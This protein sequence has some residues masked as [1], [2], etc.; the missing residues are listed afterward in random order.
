MGDLLPGERLL[1]TGSPARARTFRADLKLPGLLLAALVSTVAVWSGHGP[2]NTSFVRDLLVL[3]TVLE[4][5][6]LGLAAYWFLYRKPRTLRE[7]V[8][9]ISDRRVVVSDNQHVTAAFLDQLAEPVVAGGRDL[10]VRDLTPPRRSWL[11]P[12]SVG[13][14]FTPAEPPLFPALHDLPDAELVRRQLSDARQR[15]LRGLLDIEPAGF[16]PGDPPPSDFVPAPG[17]QILW[18]GHPVDLPWWFG[19][20]DVFYSVYHGA[21]LAAIP[22][23]FAWAVSQPHGLLP[24]VLF[25]S[26]VVLVFGYPAFG[27]LLHRRARIK[28]STYVLTSSRLIAI[29]PGS[30]IQSPL[31]Q[32]LPPEERGSSL[33]MAAAWPGPLATTP[34]Q[35]LWPAAKSNPPQLIGLPDPQAVA[36]L[37]CSAQLAERA[38]TWA[39]RARGP[40]T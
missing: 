35:L 2:A 39:G 34:G 38:R 27:R 40:V 32:L 4:V 33:F 22:V 1:W 11:E 30:G 8:Y 6:A 20:E 26:F 9:Q 37:I 24:A 21:F 23:F 18:V 14:Q 29:W 36:R 5:I 3:M 31:A 12:R 25:S 7:T 10:L 17:E 28:R 16:L 15:M 19:S 13:R